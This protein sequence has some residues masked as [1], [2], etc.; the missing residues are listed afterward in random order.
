V[1]LTKRFR[2]G[3]HKTVVANGINYRFAKK[4]RVALLGKNGAGKSSLLKLISGVMR[5]DSGQVFREGQISWPIGLS[6]K[7]RSEL[8]ADQNVRMVAEIYERCPDATSQFVKKFCEIKHHFDSPIQFYSSGMKAKVSFGLAM[9]FQ[10]DYYLIDE[11]TSVGD[12]VFKNKAKAYLDARLE[13]SGCIFVTHSTSAVRRYCNEVLV[14]NNGKLI[15]FDNIDEGI[16]H[17][18]KL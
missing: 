7:F 2:S 17:Y 16:Y 8:S 1:N 11:T 14:L 13:N 4:E 9:A 3:K 6:G 12:Q 15:H 18:K 10:F 5:P